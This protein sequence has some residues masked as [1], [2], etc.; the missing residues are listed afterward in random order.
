MSWNRGRNF[1][2][3]AKR[4]PVMLTIVS[5]SLVFAA[6]E[7]FPAFRDV[8]ARVGITLLNISGGA[9]KDYILEA[10]GNG[11]AFLDHDN[12]GDMDLVITNGS[13][14]KNYKSGGDPMA[15][16]YENTGERFVDVTQKAGITA[17]GWG[18]GI[19]A[20][21]YDNDGYQD[22]YLTAYGRNVL[23]RNTGKGAFVDVTSKARVGDTRWGTNCAFAD[24]DRDGNVDLYVANYMTFSET[25]VPQRGINEK[26]GYMGAPVFCGPQGYP[27]EADV[28][29]R[30]NGDGTFTDV[31]E[32]AGVRDPGYYGFG[33]IFGD[34]DNDGWPD[35]Y[36]ANDGNP[37]FLFRNN[38][39]GTFTEMGLLSGT[40]LNEAGRAQSGMGVSAADYDNDGLFDIFVTNFAGDTNT[41]YR[42]LGKLLFVDRTAS[43]GMGEVALPY[44]G[45]GTGIEDFDNDGLRD[46]FVA[47]GHV[48]PEVDGL[49]V[50]QSYMQRK[51]LYRNLGNGRFKE[52]AGDLDGDLLTA[53]SARGTAFADFDNDGDIDVLVVN[54]NDRPNLFR[55]EGGNRNHWITF[56]LEGVRS[57]RDAIGARIEINA[58]GRTQVAEV[59]SGSS[60]LSHNDIRVHF[61]LGDGD[62]IDRVRVHWPNSAMQEFTNLTADRFVTIREGQG[63]SSTSSDRKP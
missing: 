14:L 35:I 29:Y 52:I 51:E 15:A 55:N 63:F 10:N 7:D 40:A 20:A 45:W 4:T 38:R 56:R 57:N 28:L 13:T 61:G 42:N 62:R 5:A 23:Y 37:N 49:N 46:I 53:H 47:N 33:V 30:N 41:L 43:A 50:G 36:V 16:L 17:R 8:A 59:R 24:Y 19:C 6:T 27:G 11:A 60:Y 26:C 3:N 32:R 9:D 12:D 21:D 18:S 48:Y 58:G 34:F 39:N 1:F 31:T 22:F 54:L 44:L 25:T 2:L